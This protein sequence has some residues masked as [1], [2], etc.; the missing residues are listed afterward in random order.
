MQKL[1]FNSGLRETKRRDLQSVLLSR[2]KLNSSDLHDRAVNGDNGKCVQ[3]RQNEEWKV[4]RGGER[5]V[6]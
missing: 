5:S 4:Y 2:S 3:K 1:H 6:S